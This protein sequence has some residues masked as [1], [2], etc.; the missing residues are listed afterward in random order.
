MNRASAQLWQHWADGRLCL[1]RCVSCGRGQHPPGPVCSRCGSTD[2]GFDDVTGPAELVAWST[3]RR[4]PS[5]AFAGEVPYTLVIARVGSGALVEARATDDGAADAW[6][7]G[8]EVRLALGEINGAALPV[9]TVG[10]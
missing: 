10:G 9:A 6:Q 2:V 5:A 4:A 1:Q 8:A 3:V 7:V